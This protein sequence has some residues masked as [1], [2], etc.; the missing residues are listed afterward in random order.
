MRVKLTQISFLVDRNSDRL[1]V[2]PARKLDSV[3]KLNSADTVGSLDEQRLL[4][5]HC[6]GKVIDNTG[7]A[8][9]LSLGLKFD[10]LTL[11]LIKSGGSSLRPLNAVYLILI[12]EKILIIL[13]NELTKASRDLESVCTGSLSCSGYKY[14]GSSILIAEVSG[15]LILYLNIV[16]FSVL[17]EAIYLYRHLTNYPLNKVDLVRTLVNKDSSAFTLPG[18]SPA[19]AVIVLLGTEPVGNYPSHSL[20]LTDTALGNYLT[21]LLVKRVGAL[22]EHHAEKCLVF[23]RGG[24]HFFYLLCVNARRLLADDVD[25][26]LETL[27]YHLGMLIVGNFNEYCIAKSAV[28]HLYVVFKIYGIALR[29]SF[30]YVFD[31]CGIDITYCAYNCIDSLA[32]LEYIKKIMCSL[33]SKS[34]NSISYAHFHILRNLYKIFCNV[35][36]ASL[37]LCES[38]GKES[39]VILLNNKIFSTRLTS[40]LYHAL[41]V[42]ITVSDR[43]IAGLYSPTVLLN[44]NLVVLQMNTVYSSF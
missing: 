25:A 14:A 5:K 3:H 16:P 32:R 4:A 41:K 7:M 6:R 40:S 18:C 29:C 19:S 1:A 37:Y 26:S 23:L 8:R 12:P 28:E 13:A 34:Y 31:L 44:L 11:R 35:F 24:I 2:V 39:R 22:I 9:I 30:L 36:R 43:T 21:H 20:K 27:H 33:V 10:L 15:Y 42:D 38:I 17:T